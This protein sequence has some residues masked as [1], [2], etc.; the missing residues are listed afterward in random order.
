MPGNLLTTDVLFPQFS[1][2][3]TSDQKI[4]KI[5]DYLYMLREQL[6][7]SMNNLGAE[8]FNPTEL[9]GM[10]EVIR[11]PIYVALSDQEGHINELSITAEGFA[12]RIADAENNIT[13]LTAT[14]EGISAN[15]SSLSKET[16]DGLDTLSQSITAVDIK[17][18]G[19][20][21]AVSNLSTTTGENF[22][23]VN[24]SISAIDQKADGISA[25]VQ[26]LSTT[27]TDEFTAVKESI[28][29]VSL[30]ADGIATSVSSLETVTNQEMTTIKQ[31]VSTIDQKADGISTKV[32]TLETTIDSEMT[33]I[34]QSVSTVNQKADGISTSVQTLTTTVN[35]QTEKISTLEQTATSITSTVSSLSTSTRDGFTE[36]NRS[37]STVSQTA[38]KI[39]WLIN[40]G[41]S[42]SS[43]TLTS[44]AA[45]LVANEIDLTGYVTISSLGKNGSTAIDGSRITT[46]TISAD[47]IDT[48]SMK[49]KKIYDSSNDVVFT[50][51]GY[52]VS[53][54]KTSNSRTTIYGEYIDICGSIKVERTDIKICTHWQDKLSFFGHY[55]SSRQSVSGSNTDAKLTSLINALKAYGLI[56]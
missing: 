5:M 36:V 44:R 6:R 18:D 45:K 4:V 10:A 26:T 40:S 23:A 53:I 43:F 16:K 14:A 27:T 11:K 50:A 17:A 25:T 48:N 47:H 12:A 34:K 32:S 49:I 39:Y 38:D 22:T 51:S 1:I 15:V 2:K 21:T 56:S 37:I 31:S 33:T 55:A 41:G 20:S 24:Q 7:W 13:T 3:E 9:N 19:I 42:A 29:A 46:G 8:N 30:K 52:N 28:T 35:G 54:G